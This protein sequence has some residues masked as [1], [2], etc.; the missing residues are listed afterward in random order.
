MILRI[1]SGTILAGLM[2]ASLAQAAPGDVK[3]GAATQYVISISKIELCTN[4]TCSGVIY[5]INTSTGGDIA[6]CPANGDCFSGGPP[7]D[8]SSF[9]TKGTV[10][11]HTRTTMSRSITV[12]GTI[13]GVESTGGGTVTC[14]IPSSVKTVPGTAPAA[15]DTTGLTLPPRFVSATLL[16][17]TT[18]NSV[19]G[20]TQNYI[21]GETPPK[22]SVRFGT[23]LAIAAV[24]VPACVTF[25]AV[26]LVVVTITNR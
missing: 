19:V 23:Q 26:P 20:L 8:K 14:V 3:Q 13:T 17:A 22:V 9:P 16:D 25:P 10:F 24:A 2:G 15:V 11:T 1:A 7:L 21:V 12:A 4:S 18:F 5:T 6:A